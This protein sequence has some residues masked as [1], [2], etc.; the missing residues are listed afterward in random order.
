MGTKMFVK[1]PA[2]QGTFLGLRYKEFEE[3]VTLVGNETKY[4]P[5]NADCN[6]YEIKTVRA[7]ASN[8]AKVSV[9]IADRDTAGDVCYES[10]TEN[11]VYDI[12]AV[13]LEDKTLQ[14][15]IHVFIKNHSA[16]NTTV[17]LVIKIL[18]LEG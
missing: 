8:S 18:T 14:Q 5:I 13:P 4:V 17:R 11:V 3:S 15:K 12:A 7:E 1:R 6:I 16:S 9:S 2:V 10:L